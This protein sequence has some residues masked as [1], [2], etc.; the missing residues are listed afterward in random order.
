MMNNVMDHSGE[1]IFFSS[2][3]MDAFL[4]FSGGKVF[5]RDRYDRER[6]AELEGEGPGTTVYM[7]LSNFTQ[8]QSRDVF[9]M[10]TNEDN[11]FTKTRVPLRMMFD[12]SPVSRSQAKR[13]CNRFEE[14]REIILDFDGLD[15]MGQGFA[16]QIFAVYQKEHPEL[17]IIPINMSDGVRSMYL[18]VLEKQG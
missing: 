17:E 14:F 18:H 10:Y 4:I 12:A 16:H 1:G 9:D 15:W 6:L 7:K 11:Q 2:K 5:S 13:V 8:K 3:L